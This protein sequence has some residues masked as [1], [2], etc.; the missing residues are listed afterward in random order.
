MVI[1]AAN[2]GDRN[3]RGMSGA[4]ALGSMI[5]ER[6]G[7]VPQMVGSA[8]RVVEG[9]WAMQL[10]AAAPN[11]GQLAAKLGPLLDNDGRII[12]TMGR[13][14]AGLATLPL[15][16][17]R[18]P[19]AAVVWFDA[20]GDC[21]APADDGSTDLNYLGGM[22]MTGAA[23]EWVTGLGDGLNLAN[24][25]LV[26]ARDLD[27]PERERIAS[28]QI[29]HVACGPDVA[30]R[31][32]SAIAGRSVYVHLDCDVLDAGLV[33]TEYQSPDGLSYSELRSA[34]DVLA[35]HDVVGL[36]IAEYE[37]HWPDGRSNDAADLIHAIDPVLSV[38]CRRP[39]QRAERHV[40]AD[41]N[42][43]RV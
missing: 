9:G 34:F 40:S 18:R 14:A 16:A 41:G 37:S 7:L 13:C 17:T 26:G 22:V 35:G 38:L 19:D 27:P 23:G 2:A 10:A 3:E 11:L 20:H 4:V 42:Q 5:A 32:A 30:A 33:A 31:L 39:S 24:V 21:N 29:T 25:V 1:Y 12:V 43:I 28:G 6:M 15:V 36:E 8:C